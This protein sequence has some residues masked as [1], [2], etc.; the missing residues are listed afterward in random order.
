MSSCGTGPDR[1]DP[2]RGERLDP[3]LVVEDQRR[4]GGPA[5]ERAVGLRAVGERPLQR[6]GEVTLA[7]CD[8]GQAEALERMVGG[9]DMPVAEAVGDDRTAADDG[10]EHGQ[11]GAR[12]D[13][14]VGG[15]HHVA[16]PVGETHHLEPRIA[17]EALGHAAADVVVAPAQAED[18]RVLHLER[19]ARRPDQVAD[20]PAASG[21]SDHGPLSRKPE[22]V[23]SLGT[24]ARRE[25]GGGSRRLGPAHAPGTRDL[26]HLLGRFRVG[27][28]VQVDPGMGPEL[29]PGE[30]GDRRV[31]RDLQHPAATHLAEDRRHAGIGRDDHVRIVGADQAHQTA[32]AEQRQQPLRAAS[33]SARSA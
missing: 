2:P 5:S 24:R 28:E 13:Q 29:Q 27:D 12:V 30:V 32:L 17:R 8:L 4:R 14:G 16:H 3:A 19:D 21:D 20:A 15:R 9:A 1:P 7:T 11:P 18:R 23:A 6:R 33:A 22:R 25:E 10:L 31:A 26:L